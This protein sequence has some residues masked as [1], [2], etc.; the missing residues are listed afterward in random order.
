MT[1]YTKPIV[2]RAIPYCEHVLRQRSF[3]QKI[4]KLLYRLHGIFL[5]PI[6]SGANARKINTPSRH[7]ELAAA[8]FGRFVSRGFGSCRVHSSAHTTEAAL[9]EQR[10]RQGEMLQCVCVCVVVRMCLQCR[11]IYAPAFTEDGQT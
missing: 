3:R 4:I 7:T 11:R 1:T 10:Q 2:L 9:K 5:F 8:L 6:Q